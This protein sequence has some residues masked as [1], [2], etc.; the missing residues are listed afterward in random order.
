MAVT[1]IPLSQFNRTSS[2]ITLTNVSKLNCFDTLERMNDCLKTQKQKNK[3]NIGCQINVK[4][5]N[6]NELVY[7]TLPLYITLTR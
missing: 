3:S 4:K 5:L 6:I 2:L 1:L 7:A